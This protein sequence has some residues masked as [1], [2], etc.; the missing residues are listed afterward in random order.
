MVVA[1]SMSAVRSAAL[2]VVVPETISP[3]VSESAT[4]ALFIIPP[5]CWFMGFMTPL[6]MVARALAGVSMRLPVTRERLITEAR[7]IFLKVRFMTV[8]SYFFLNDCR[9]LRLFPGRAC[10]L[11][12]RR[13]LFGGLG[14]SC[15]FLPFSV[16]GLCPLTLPST[17]RNP[18]DPLMSEETFSVFPVVLFLHPILRSVR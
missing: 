5:G 7:A 12:F 3:A 1:F 18:K 16:S 15:S 2:L 14:L 8:S 6:F 13:I 10:H 11:S 4:M 9:V 17:H